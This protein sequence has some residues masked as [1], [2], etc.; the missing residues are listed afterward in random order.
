MDTKALSKRYIPAMH[1]S[2]TFIGFGALEIGRD[3]GVGTHGERLHPNN[4]SAQDTLDEV[5]NIGINVIDTANA[6]HLSQSHIGESLTVK[7]NRN[8]LLINS[9]V[10]ELSMLIQGNN[11]QSATYDGI[12]CNNPAST[13]DF[14]AKAIRQHVETSLHDIKLD[15]LDIVFIHFGPNPEKI[16]RDKIVITE[17]KKLKKEGKLHFIGASL[18]DP[19]LTEECIN[20]GDFDAIEVE[21]NLLNRSNERVIKL[22]HDKGLAVFVRGAL[23]TGALTPKIEP[24]LQDKNLPYADKIKSLLKLANNDYNTLIALELE[25]LYE[26]KNI[27][28]VLIGASN[29]DQLIT[30]IN[31]L[32]NFNDKNMLK[33]AQQLTTRN[34]YGPFTDSLDAYFKDFY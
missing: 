4:S 8:K 1:K 2:V 32:N 21:Y 30:D 23:G 26:N 31:L 6:Y 17:L 34:I 22:A 29:K 27:S 24:Y 28:S 5:C 16:I 12:Y 15:Y 3:W 33:K 20:S 9:K 14:S 7:K 11:C 13:Y 18:D 19:K 25:F 10:G